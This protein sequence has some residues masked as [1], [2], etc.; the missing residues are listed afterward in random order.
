LSAEYNILIEAYSCLAPI[1]RYPGGPVDK[2]VLAAAKRLGA[3]P[4]QVILAWVRSKGAAIVTTS[5]NKKHLEEY[6]GVSELPPLTED[7][8]ADID[9]AGANGPP[10]Y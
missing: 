4:A 3:T 2:P 10:N 7:E 5:S 8:I 1:T 9:E 6:L